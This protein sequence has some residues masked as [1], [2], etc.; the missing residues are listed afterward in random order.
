MMR[1]KC[2]YVDWAAG[3]FGMYPRCFIS[4]AAPNIILS[5][6]KHRPVPPGHTL[7]LETSALKNLSLHKEP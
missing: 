6:E 2:C 5:L 1:V 7:S 4:M 3:F